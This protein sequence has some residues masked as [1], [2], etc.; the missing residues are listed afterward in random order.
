MFSTARLAARKQSSA[1][2]KNC[3]PEC[4]HC[5]FFGRDWYFVCFWCFCFVFFVVVIGSLCPCLFFVRVCVC[6]CL[7]CGRDW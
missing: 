6:V 7:F 4:D 1:G 5:A 3:A 2:W